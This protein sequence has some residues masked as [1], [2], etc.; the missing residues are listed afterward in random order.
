MSDSSFS[1]PLN[2]SFNLPLDTI[3][4]IAFLCLLAGYIIFS[5]ILQYHW[6]QYSTNGPVTTATLVTYYLLTLPIL[7]FLGII[8][9]IA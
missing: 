9:L 2:L 8:I 6:R 1:N 5:V 3:L 7:L 4:M